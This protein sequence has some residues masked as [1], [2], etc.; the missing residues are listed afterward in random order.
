M[1]SHATSA[2]VL[3]TTLPGMTKFATILEMLEHQWSVKKGLIGG[4]VAHPT[5]LVIF[6]QV[7][8][9]FP[10]EHAL[11]TPAQWDQLLI[12]GGNDFFRI[13]HTLLAHILCQCSD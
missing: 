12:N 10:A 13:I 5:P 3:V 11:Y 2:R 9:F 8:I 6:Y 7:N 1:A 4:P